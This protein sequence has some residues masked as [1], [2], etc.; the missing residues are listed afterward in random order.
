MID[1]PQL[2]PERS[3]PQRTNLP[4]D[5]LR[6]G[7]RRDRHG[8]VGLKFNPVGRLLIDSNVLVKLNDT[9]LRDKVT[10]LVGMEYAF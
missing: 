8:A 9:G 4:A 3:P 7:V 10:P 5:R 1:S 6:D 2:D